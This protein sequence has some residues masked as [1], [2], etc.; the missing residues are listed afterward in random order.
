MAVGDKMFRPG[1]FTGAGESKVQGRGEVDEN[2]RS[3]VKAAEKAVRT[4]GL[5]STFVQGLVRSLATAKQNGFKEILDSVES[6]EALM[7]DGTL[8]TV[9]GIKAVKDIKERVNNKLLGA[10]GGSFY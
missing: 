2:V 10:V 9:S 3:L 6:Y 5:P 7:R 8:G 4:G 1:Q